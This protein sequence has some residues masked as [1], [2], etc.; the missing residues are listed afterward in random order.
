MLE[1]HCLSVM[2]VAAGSG[3]RGWTRLV[4]TGSQG[5]SLSG[6]RKQLPPPAPLRW[7][8]HFERKTPLHR[9]CCELL[10]LKHQPK[11][12]S[13]FQLAHPFYAQ[14]AYDRSS[15]S[16]SRSLR[17]SFSLASVRRGQT[18]RSHSS[19]HS[20][21]KQEKGARDYFKLIRIYSRPSQ[22]R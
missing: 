7:K 12:P 5:P 10:F 3:R 20:L 8:R 14:S 22:G 9:A 21:G 6:S 17:H 2:A 15:V 19:W 11:A 16:S 4:A 18:L 13:N 1:L